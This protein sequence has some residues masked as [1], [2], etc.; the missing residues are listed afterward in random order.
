MGEQGELFSLP[1]R[2]G[3]RRAP[4]LAT[5]SAAA[6]YTRYRPTRRVICDDCIRDIHARGVDVAPYPKSARWRRTCG[7]DIDHLCD[8]HKQSRQDGD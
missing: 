8:P 3:N 5:A 7:A 2:P 4:K 6:R 1:P